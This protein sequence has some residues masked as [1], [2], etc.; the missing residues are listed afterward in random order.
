LRDFNRNGTPASFVLTGRLYEEGRTT[1][2]RS[3]SEEETE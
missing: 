2:D 3:G 1:F